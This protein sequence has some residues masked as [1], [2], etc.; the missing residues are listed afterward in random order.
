M[1]FR[2]ITTTPIIDVHRERW[3]KYTLKSHQGVGEEGDLSLIEN[4]LSA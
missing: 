1:Q 4:K 3:Y 2:A